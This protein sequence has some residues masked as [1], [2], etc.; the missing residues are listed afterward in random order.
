MGGYSKSGDT[1]YNDVWR[2]ANGKDWF[3]V[4][5]AGSHWGGRGGHQVVVHGPV[6]S[7][8]ERVAVVAT[9]PT[10]SLTVSLA[11]ATTPVTLAT[12][13]ASGG[14]GGLRFE[15]E[16]A[17][18]VAAVGDDGEFVVTNFLGS[19][20]RATVTVVARDSTPVNKAAVVITMAFVSPLGVARDSAEFVVSPDYTVAVFTITATGGVGAHSFV[21]VEGPSTVTVEADTGVVSIT[22]GLTVGSDVVAVFAVRDEVGGSV[23]FTLSLEVVAEALG[24]GVIYM[25]GGSSGGDGPGK[26]ADVWRWSADGDNWELVNGAAPFGKRHNHQMVFHGGSL[27]VLGGKDDE[28]SYKADVWRSADGENWVEV[29]ISGSSWYDRKA[30][31]AVSHDGNLF[32][33]GGDDDDNLNDVWRS[34]DGERWTMVAIGNRWGE[35]RKHAVVSHG[36]NLWLMGGWS[37]SDDYRDVWRSANGE[38]WD[39]VTA[40]AGWQGRIAHQVVSHRG[41]LWVLGGMDRSASPDIQLGDVWR[42]ANGKEWFRVTISGNSWAARRVHQVV[43]YGD[44]LWLMGGL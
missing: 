13:S 36:G 31:E 26:F 14:V 22:G 20:E 12:I 15:V 28:S 35:R 3:K 2:S 39:L 25:S 34:A 42:S 18:G 23:R 16:D 32:V 19:R 8:Y 5:V 40:V 21:R 4:A 11:S 30:H 24:Q 6:P 17:Q 9:G 27:W 44:K 37:G 33:I 7:A 38:R 41:S 1:N 29:A 10:D 43:S